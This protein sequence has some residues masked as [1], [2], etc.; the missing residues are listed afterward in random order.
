MRDAIS[1]M[2][3]NLLG[4]SAEHRSGSSEESRAGSKQPQAGEEPQGELHSRI[5][6]KTDTSDRSLVSKSDV[7]V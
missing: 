4:R 6:S 1:Q 5:K 2:L 7:S 3:G